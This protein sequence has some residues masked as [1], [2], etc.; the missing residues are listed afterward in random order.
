[1]L[2]RPR[3]TTGTRLLLA[4]IAATA[5]ITACG[6]H[7]ATRQDVIARADAI[8]FQSDQS[9]RSVPSPVAAGAPSFRSP[10]Y[11]AA[12]ATYLAKVR[13]I[14]AKEARGLQAL[15]RPEQRRATLNAFIAAVAKESADYA[16]MSAAAST[17]DAGG[18]TT[19][20]SALTRN[21][22]RSLAGRYGMTQCTGVSST[23]K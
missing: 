2:H 22:A 18:V 17:G 3:A 6:G 21:P 8:C 11:L 7:S 13:P 9:I 1:M 10:A 14:V 4:T 19:A 23:T 20:L 15:P 5:T 12:F 16:S